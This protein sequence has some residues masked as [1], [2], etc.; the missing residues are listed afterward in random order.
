MACGY[1]ESSTTSWLIYT[2]IDNSR[3][4]TAAEA[5]VELALDLYSKYKEEILSLE[6]V[7]HKDC[8]KQTIARDEEAQFCSKC[9]TRL[10]IALF[11]A[12][13]FMDYVKGLHST[14]CDG[15][16]ES[17]GTKDRSF[18]FWPWRAEEIVGAGLDEIVYIAENAERV[19]LDA[20]YEVHDD[21]RRLEYEGN[22][23]THDEWRSTDWQ[24]VR[25]RGT[26]HAF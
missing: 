19:I 11:D 26:N 4:N 7:H 24:E 3:F 16:G 21:L 22:Y 8:C 25:K 13:C 15:Y 18:A 2:T 1:V 6:Y 20:L 5:V 23:E 12:N 14:D 17:E 9:G 10:K